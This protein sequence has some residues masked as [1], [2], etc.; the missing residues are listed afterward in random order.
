MQKRSAKPWS[1]GLMFFI[2]LQARWQCIRAE[3]G[4]RGADKIQRHTWSAFWWQL[5]AYFVENTK[6]VHQ[7]ALEL[8]NPESLM[9]CIKASVEA[10]LSRLGFDRA[11]FMLL[12]MKKRCFSGTYG[13][14]EAGKNQQ[15]TSYPVWLASTRSGIH[16]SVARTQSQSSTWLLSNRRPYTEGKVVGQGWNGM[17]ILREGDKPGGLDC[18]G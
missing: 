11:I 4:E 15:R 5:R 6:L 14:D 12:D 8:S 13:T 16:R 3:S 1:R 2:Q 17:L 10:A 7:V 18:N 9:H